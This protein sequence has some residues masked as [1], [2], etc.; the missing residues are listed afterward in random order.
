MN[1]LIEL[2]ARERLAEMHRRAARARLLRD[3]RHPSAAQPP[4]RGLSRP[5]RQHAVAIAR[6]SGRWWPW[7]A[8]KAKA[9]AKAKG[10][11][12]GT[13]GASLN[14]PRAPGRDACG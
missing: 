12:I 13:G 5:R 7:N 14:G 2:F 4:I 8:H 10:K 11:G 3:A 6:G 9:K 1:Y